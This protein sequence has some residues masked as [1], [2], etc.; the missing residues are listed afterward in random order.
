MVERRGGRPPERREP[1]VEVRMD[2]FKIARGESLGTEGLGTC[3]GIAFDHRPSQTGAMGH[4]PDYGR[5]EVA[6][7]ARTFFEESGADPTEVKAYLR[8]ASPAGPEENLVEFAHLTR[9]EAEEGVRE[10]GILP[11]N[12][13]VLWQSDST[14]SDTMFLDTATGEFTSRVEED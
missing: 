5:G 3:A 2:D 9:I 14:Q 4:F 7:L 10:S 6:G 1:D 11:E 8:G 12:T 13:D